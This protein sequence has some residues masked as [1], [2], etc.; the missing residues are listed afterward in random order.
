MT[1]CRGLDKSGSGQGC[2]KRGN[3]PSDSIKSR[4][5][6]KWLGNSQ[7]LSNDSTAWIWAAGWRNQLSLKSVRLLRTDRYCKAKCSILLLFAAN[8]PKKIAKECVMSSSVFWVI[9]QRKVVWNT[10]WEYL[11]APFFK[12]QADPSWPLK[13]GPTGS[14]EMSVSHHLTPRN[15]PEDGIMQF[16]RGG[17]LRTRK[18]CKSI[19]TASSPFMME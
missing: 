9:T 13:T 11:S 8:A 18:I 16:N 12:G 17:S 5:F 7:H 3:E 1:G 4:K 14:T 2:S 10:F 19:P 15:N 6:F